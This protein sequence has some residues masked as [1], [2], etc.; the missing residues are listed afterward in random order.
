MREQRL[1][2]LITVGRYLVVSSEQV[3]GPYGH[4]GF[5]DMQCQKQF[6]KCLIGH[7]AAYCKR[8]IV[9]QLT[10]VMECIYHIYGI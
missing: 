2:T 5:Y 4:F 8:T 1:C 3:N 9:M 10:I 6:L 7:Q